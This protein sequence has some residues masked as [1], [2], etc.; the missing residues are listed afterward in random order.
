MEQRLPQN[1]GAP[2]NHADYS[3]QESFNKLSEVS[4]KMLDTLQYEFF[5]RRLKR[6]L[7]AIELLPLKKS[8]A[9]LDDLDDHGYCLLHYFILIGHLDCLLMLKMCGASLSQSTDE[10]KPRTPLVLAAE[11]GHDAIVRALV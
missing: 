5:V 9:L 3:I 10:I 4:D 8:K 7:E 6:L 11:L 2:P 1:S